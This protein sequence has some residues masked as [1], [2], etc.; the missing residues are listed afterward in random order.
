MLEEKTPIAYEIEVEGRK[1]QLMSNDDATHIKNIEKKIVFI[2]KNIRE[3]GVQG[4]FFQH[5]M[6]AVLILADEIV[7][8]EEDND[9]KLVH[10]NQKLASFIQ[11]L[12]QSLIS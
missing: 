1:F 6:K 12:D 5:A 4:D 10:V 11:E 2:F 9:E 7:R 3:S 8:K